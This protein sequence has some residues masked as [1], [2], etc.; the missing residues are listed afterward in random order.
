MLPPIPEHIGQAPGGIPWGQSPVLFTFAAAFTNKKTFPLNNGKVCQ[1]FDPKF[2]LY[3][4]GRAN[5]DL[6]SVIFLCLLNVCLHAR[7][8]YSGYNGCGTVT[9]F[10]R[11]FLIFNFCTSKQ[12]TLHFYL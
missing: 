11:S 3:P 1:N 2:C 5:A 12:C 4:A 6:K 7:F 8:Q 9:D 10:H